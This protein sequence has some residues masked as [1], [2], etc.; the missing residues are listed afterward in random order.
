MQICRLLILGLA[1]IVLASACATSPN[2]ERGKVYCPAC[3][4]D[5]DALFEKRF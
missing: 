5:F 4:T 2:Q 3:G 1:L